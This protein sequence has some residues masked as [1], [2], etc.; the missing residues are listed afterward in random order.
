MYRLDDEK[1][2][3]D[4]SLGRSQ[5]TRCCAIARERSDRG[6]CRSSSVTTDESVQQDSS[7]GRSQ[8][9]LQSQETEDCSSVSNSSDYTSIDSKTLVSIVTIHERQIVNRVSSTDY[10]SVVN[11]TIN[12]MLRSINYS[13]ETTI[14]INS[15]TA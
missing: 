1:A 4:S 10:R 7:L 6:L 13:E 3:Q 11:E 14:M 9:A 8:V 2:K 12:R 15:I 5:L